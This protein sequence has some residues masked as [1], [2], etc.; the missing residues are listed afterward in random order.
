[1]CV[2]VRARAHQDGDKGL[3]PRAAARTLLG[4]H[5]TPI[6]SNATDARMSVIKEKDM[7]SAAGRRLLVFHRWEAGSCF[8]RA[9]DAA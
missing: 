7:R 4:R 6:A 8:V 5:S 1:M 2:C 9:D 3:A